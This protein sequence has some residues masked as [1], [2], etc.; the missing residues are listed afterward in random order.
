MGVVS[1][2]SAQKFYSALLKVPG[3][4]DMSNLGVLAQRVQGSFSA[5]G[6]VYTRYITDAT[7]IADALG[8][9]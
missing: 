1:A 7:K 6:S 4:P 9:Q 8:V 5:D 2:T 3:W